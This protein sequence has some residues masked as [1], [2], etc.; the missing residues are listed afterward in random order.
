MPSE[1]KTY[2]YIALAVI[3]LSV[4]GFFA[5]KLYSSGEQT[6]EVR[7]QK[8]ATKAVIHNTQ[9]KSNAQIQQAAAVAVFQADHAAPA[10]PAPAVVCVAAQPRGRS[11]VPGDRGAAG[12]GDGRTAVPEESD[13]PFD[14]APAVIQDAREADDQIRLLQALIREYQAAGVVAK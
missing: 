11:E 4:T 10:A 9:V 2:V 12:R 7:D 13:V 14:P 5:Y 3:A 1:I 6:I 8:V